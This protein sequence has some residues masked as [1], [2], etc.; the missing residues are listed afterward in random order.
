[1]TDLRCASAADAATAAAMLDAFAREFDSPSDGAEVLTRR[2]AALVARP[3][4]VLLLAGPADAPSGLALTCLRPTAFVDGEAAFLEELYVIPAERNRGLGTALLRRAIDEAHARGA[5]HFEIGVDED[6][7]DARRFYER[8]GF[9]TLA[10]AD[11]TERMLL[12]ERD[13]RSD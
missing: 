6:D 8:H 7:V 10:A 11:S 12:Y 2:L 9:S 13:L 5:E 4:V 1:M 3:D